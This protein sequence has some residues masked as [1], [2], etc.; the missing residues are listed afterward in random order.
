M[1]EQLDRLGEVQTEPAGIQHA[2]IQKELWEFQL[3]WKDWVSTK[4]KEAL[5]KQV[6]QYQSLAQQ[7]RT[8]MRVQILDLQEWTRV[9]KSGRSQNLF[10]KWNFS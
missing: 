8:K 2:Q 5:W 10:L 7:L 1:Q 6:W 4:T 3:S 9:T